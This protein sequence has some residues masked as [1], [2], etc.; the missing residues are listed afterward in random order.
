MQCQPPVQS[1][2]RWF[3]GNVHAHSDRSDG[4][5][6]PGA[7]ADWYGS[8]G[9]DF[10]AITDHGRVTRL[11]PRPDDSRSNGLLML[12]GT[13]VT[14]WDDRAGAFHHLLALLDPETLDSVASLKL[15][16]PQQI[17]DQL[18]AG[19]ALVFS[20]HPYWLGLSSA[21]TGALRGTHGIEVYNH[22]CQ[23]ERARGYSEQQWDELL[24][25]GKR[26]WGL[27]VDD[28]H[29]R[30]HD[31]GGGWVM[32]RAHE[33][34]PAAIIGALRSGD[35]YS[36]QGPDITRF[37]VTGDPGR[38]PGTEGAAEAV[39]ECSRCRKIVFLADRWLGAVVAPERKN[40]GE[41]LVA[42]QYRLTGKET[43]VRAVCT[44]AEGRKAWTNPIMLPAPGAEQRQLRD[45]SWG[46]GRD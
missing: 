36:T 42:G 12:P 9:Y 7:L 6:P 25:A 39:I 3:K 14:A 38:P 5:L 32:V 30:E 27:A 28:C 33:L 26:M 41:L 40:G 43:Y 10:L 35:F 34:T 45:L 20:A 4:R 15:G 16:P 21:E 24:V 31:S 2:L 17:V 11:G 44:D 8:H 29:W 18:V 19:G 37:A 13:E 1:G 22:L 46:G 23:L